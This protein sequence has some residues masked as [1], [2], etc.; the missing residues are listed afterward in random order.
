MRIVCFNI[1]YFDVYLIGNNVLRFQSDI[2][3]NEYMDVWNECSAIS[4]VLDVFSLSLLSDVL[5]RGYHTIL[6]IFM[7][8]YGVS[9]THFM[10]FI[11]WFESDA[12]RVF[13]CSHSS[14]I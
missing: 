6:I 2:L 3:S 10:I 9:D 7:D 8:V 13:V 1:R 5:T 11:L 4:F 12:I 14:R